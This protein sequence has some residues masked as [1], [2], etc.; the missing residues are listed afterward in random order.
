MIL[1]ARA[2]LSLGG[3]KVA[4]L[5]GT[6]WEREWGMTK[7]LV[8]LFLLTLHLEALQDGRIHHRRG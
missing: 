3:S 4:F 8:R 7:V 2:R 5:G 6:Q 1:E